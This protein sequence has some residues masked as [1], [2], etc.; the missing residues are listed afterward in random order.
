MNIFKTKFTTQIVADIPI[1]NAKNGVDTINNS[2]L[3]YIKSKA[4]TRK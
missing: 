2:A 4:I 3:N 1:V